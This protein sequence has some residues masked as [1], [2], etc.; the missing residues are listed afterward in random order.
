VTDYLARLFEDVIADGKPVARREPS[1][2]VQTELIAHQK[3]ALA[4]MV[5][6][7]NSGALPPFW[8]PHKVRVGC[9]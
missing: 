8:E 9:C 7:E 2:A 4:W 3:E 1:G 5:A 6:R